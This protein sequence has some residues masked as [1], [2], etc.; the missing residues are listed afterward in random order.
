[1]KN[2]E[3]S[4][5]TKKNLARNLKKLMKE[6]PLSK[7]SISELVR[8]SNVNRKTF[9]Y[10]FSGINDLFKWMLEEEAVHIVR[11]FDLNKDYKS[12]ILFVMN[13]IEGNVE[14]LNCAYDSMG[15][16]GLKDFF[17]DDFLDITQKLINLIEDDNKI[18][19]S[20]DFKNF[21]ARMYAGAIANMIIDY[22]SEERVQSKNKIADYLIIILGS[23][24]KSSLIS[25]DK[26]YSKISYIIITLS[27]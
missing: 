13:Y 25:F 6:K 9:Y 26:E 1:M 21:L 15:R 5:N 17:Y 22:F 27:K 23:S 14:I 18:C 2:E 19:V 12:A 24:I 3:I 7:I 11:Q 10:H 4:L 16:E 8:I 20:S